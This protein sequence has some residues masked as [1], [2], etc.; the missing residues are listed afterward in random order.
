MEPRASQVREAAQ[1]PR[2]ANTHADTKHQKKDRWR[3]WQGAKVRPPTA[4]KTESK[5]NPLPPPISTAAAV[6]LTDGAPAGTLPPPRPPSP[7][8]GPPQEAN[9]TRRDDRQKSGHSGPRDKGK[10]KGKSKDKGKFKG[11]SKHRPFRG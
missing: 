6:P 5:A 1:S 4:P 9:F 3:V 2:A 11:R 10:G 7:P 8:L